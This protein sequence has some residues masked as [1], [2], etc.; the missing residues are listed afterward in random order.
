[1]RPDK[2]TIYDVATRAGV[3]KSLVSLVLQGSTKVSERRRQS[4]LAAIEELDYRPSRAAAALAG[5]RTR[6]LGVVIDDFRNPWFV[7]LLEG[8]RAGLA[9]TGVHVSVADRDLNTHR[10]ESAVDGFVAARV[11]GLVVA[12][13]LTADEAA[14]LSRLG[15]PVVVAGIRA[16]EVPGADIV[17]ADEAHGAALAVDHLHGLGHR[18][19]GHLTGSG[20]SARD[21]ARGYDERM[22]ALSLTAHIE[23][24]GGT[25]ERSGYT[26]AARL[27]EGVP[28]VTAILAANDTMAVGALAALRERGLRTPEDVS[29][30]GIDD[31]PLATSLLIDLT[32]VDIRS[33]GIG[34]AAA[35]AVLARIDTPDA[36]PQV[37]G[38]DPE[39]V[40]RRTT[41]PAES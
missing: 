38:I 41:G 23:G 28:D 9:D 30:V 12:G 21:R 2:V 6:S 22:T 17:R 13:E 14:R 11:D 15:M 29:V 5:R 26:A 31:S 8:L 36:P 35:H 40:I 19:I 24:S 20:G 10:G 18:V 3:S 33:P 25:D 7:G 32:S 27:L 39:L 4:V 37:I 1:M 34:E 16:Q